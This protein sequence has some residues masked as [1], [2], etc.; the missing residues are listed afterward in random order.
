MGWYPLWVMIWHCC[1]ESIIQ[2]NGLTIINQVTFS[3][4]REL[5]ISILSHEMA[6]DSLL[7]E[8]R[9][10][11]SATVCLQNANLERL[12][13]GLPRVVV[14]MF[15]AI[16]ILICIVPEQKF[17]LLTQRQLNC[18]DKRKRMRWKEHIYPTKEKAHKL[19][20]VTN[21]SPRKVIW[22]SAINTANLAWRDSSE[23]AWVTTST[24]RSHDASSKCTVF[25][26]H[27]L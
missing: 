10:H 5:N 8:T 12:L 1:T 3:H 23:D 2:H 21:Y 18:T 9:P 13:I 26:V 25:L 16:N 6:I 27:K 19:E 14:L 7:A 11:F 22:I 15:I 17:V 24:S 20:S 4:F